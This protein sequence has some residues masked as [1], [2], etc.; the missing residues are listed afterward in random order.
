MVSSLQVRMETESRFGLQN[1]RTSAQA[2]IQFQ[3]KITGYQ[4]RFSNSDVA[5]KAIVIFTLCGRF[6]DIQAGV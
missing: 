2:I 5:H 4:F 6:D 3:S 1:V